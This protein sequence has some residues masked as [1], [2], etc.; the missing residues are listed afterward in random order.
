M[1]IYQLLDKELKIIVLRKLS[2]LQDNTDRQLNEPGKQYINK[3]RSLT[4]R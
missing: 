1:E 3:M 4:K 2:E